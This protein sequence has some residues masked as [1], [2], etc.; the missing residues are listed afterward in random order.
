MMFKRKLLF[1][2][3]VFLSLEIVIASY[4]Y[5][6]YQVTQKSE[7]EYVLTSIRTVTIIA[8]CVNT[9]MLFRS[10]IVLF[11]EEALSRKITNA[12]ETSAITT[13]T[14]HWNSRIRHIKEISVTFIIAA[15]IWSLVT[16]ALL[17]IDYR[18]VEQMFDWIGTILLVVA[19]LVYPIVSR[20]LK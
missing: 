20:Y 16:M 6:D 4:I 15:C 9:I 14:K 2:F 10:G 7:L 18:Y 12:T 19:V 1:R 17:F 8:L 5:L 13:L 11:M 3:A